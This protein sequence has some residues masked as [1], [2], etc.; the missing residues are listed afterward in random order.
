MSPSL[1]FTTVT[2]EFVLETASRQNFLLGRHEL[3]FHKR[4]SISLRN[5]RH[6]AFACPKNRAAIDQLPTNANN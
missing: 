6:D 3:D 2:N 5:F 4:N 1:T